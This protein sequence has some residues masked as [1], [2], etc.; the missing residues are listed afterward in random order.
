MP[1]TGQT[2]RSWARERDVTRRPVRWLDSDRRKLSHSDLSS[3]PM[4]TGWDRGG[5]GSTSWNLSTS[6][7]FQYHYS[8]F[9]PLHQLIHGFLHIVVRAR[10]KKLV[11]RRA[12]IGIFTGSRWPR[13]YDLPYHK[14]VQW[15]VWWRLL[16][17]WS[18]RYDYAGFG[19]DSR[20]LWLLRSTWKKALSKSGSP[21]SHPH[22]RAL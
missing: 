1:E 18:T 17:M 22:S 16:P 13:G 10:R 7:W 9:S 2:S 19:K 21:Y 20:E 5:L 14:H 15:I 12:V 4:L 3:P 11:L 8:L 6:P